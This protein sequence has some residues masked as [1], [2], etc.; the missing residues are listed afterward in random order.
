MTRS[1]R[2][3]TQLIHAG[4]PSPRICGSAAV[5]IFQSTVFEN[6][7]GTDY[8]DI[9]YPRL[10]NLP[11]HEVLRG[12][13]AALEEG[14]DALVAASGM[15][16]IS[17]SLLTVAENGGHVLVQSG[18]YGGAVGLFNSDLPALGIS[19]SNF[20][21]ADPASWEAALRPETR[22]IYVEA[23]TNPLMQVP[24]LKAV[25]EFAR[26]HKI[27]SMIDNTFT[28][29]VNFRPAEIGFDL[30]LHSATKYLNGHTD[31]VAG[32]VIGRQELVA[33]IESLQ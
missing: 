2:I 17:T 18:I 29:P 5:P 12:K 20:D 24:D 21:G 33:K 27:V 7:D 19:H 11:N 22:A 15:A 6:T 31:I 3:E 32:A 13:L 14:E 4:E 30:S 16:A 8:H 9:R 26:A 25:V 1:H 10:S 28:S 23:I